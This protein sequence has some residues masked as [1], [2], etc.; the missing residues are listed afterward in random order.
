MDL[1]FDPSALK[2]DDLEGIG[3]GFSSIVIRIKGTKIVAK[4]FPPLDEDQHTERKIYEHLQKDGGGHPNVLRYFGRSPPDNEL[5]R[6]GLLFEYHRRGILSAYFGKMETLG[7]SEA[8]RRWFVDI[9]FTF[10]EST[11]GSLISQPIHNYS[12]PYQA[13][14]AVAYIH[15][16]GVVHADIGLHNFLI[17]D[18]GRLI[19]CD[20]AGSGMEGLPNTIAGGVRYSNP[21]YDQRL[22]STAEDDVFALGTVLYELE[23]GKRLYEGQSDQDIARQLRNQEFPDL[24]MIALPLRSVIEKCWT[25]EGYKADE[26]EAELGWDTTRLKAS[27]QLFN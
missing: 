14:S 21:K 27:D 23:C 16:R 26:A 9:T 12:W 19:L 10:L 24:Y 22:Y 3:I 17:H 2:N 6:G 5:L 1:P 11:E 7:V 8:E 15:S 18:D 20:F 13:V 4:T 25:L